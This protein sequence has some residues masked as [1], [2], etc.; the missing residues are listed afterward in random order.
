VYGRTQEAV[1]D[2]PCFSGNIHLLVTHNTSILI[3]PGYMGQRIS[4]PS[5][6]E[7]TLVPTCIQKTG[8][9]FIDHVVI[10]QP[11]IFTFNALEILCKKSFLKTVYIP[12]WSGENE[13]KWCKPFTTFKEAAATHGCT[14]VR[15]GKDIEIPIYPKNNS[16]SCIMLNTCNRPDIIKNGIHFANAHIAGI[17]DNKPLSFYAAVY[18]KQNIIKQETS[19]LIL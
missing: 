12:L 2:I 11:T 15:F 5:W 9:A 3:D 19:T 16:H 7:Y 6:T 18:K 17:I 4:A 10:L 1:L 14:I 13:R 8:K